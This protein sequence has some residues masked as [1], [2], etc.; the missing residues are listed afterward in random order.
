MLRRRPE[1]AGVA[2]R[3]AADFVQDR[4]DAGVRSDLAVVV[5]ELVTNAVRHGAGEIHLVL[6]MVGEARLRVAVSDEGPP[7]RLGIPA[8]R[9]VETGR[10]LFIVERLAA[11]WGVEAGAVGKTVWCELRG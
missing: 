2:R 6:S 10:G 1:T 11:S 7:G 8:R 9:R 5:S 4:I 3:I